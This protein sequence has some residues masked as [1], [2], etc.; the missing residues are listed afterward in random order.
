MSWLLWLLLDPAEDYGAPMDTV[1]RSPVCEL[2]SIEVVSK[3]SGGEGAIRGI[4]KTY[5]LR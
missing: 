5:L 4:G 2:T 1:P 3:E